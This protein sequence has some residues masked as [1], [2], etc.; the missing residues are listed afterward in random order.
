MVL[1]DVV[2]NHFGPEGNHLHAYAEPFFDAGRHTPWGAGIDY[3]KPPVRRFFIDNALYWLDGLPAGRPAARRDRPDPRPVGPELLAE[4]ARE[5]RA[6]ITDRPVHLTTEDNRNVTHLHERQAGGVS[7]TPPNGTTTC[8]TRPMCWPPARPT[9]TTA[10]SRTTPAATSPARWPRASPSRAPNAGEPSA[11]LPPTAFVDFLQNH[12]QTGN[13]ALGER[14]VTLTDPATHDALTAILLLSP[15]IPLMFMGEDWGETRPFLFFADFA[16]D[17]GRAV[18][19]GRRREFADFPAFAGHT[20]DIPDPVDP[21]TFAASRLDWARRDSPEGREARE[22]VRHLLHL[23]RE[24]IVPHL[25][26]RAAMPG[27]CGKRARAASPSTGASA[28]CAFPCAPTSATR[29][30]PARGGGRPSPPRGRG[31][32]RAALGR[33]LHRGGPMKLPTATYRLQFRGGMDFDRAT[34]LVPYLD[35]LGISHLYAAP[36]FTATPGSAHGYDITDPTEIDPALGGRA[37]LERLS[38]ALTARGMGL[39]LDIVPNHMA[40]APE[41]PWLRDVLRHGAE[42]ASP[43]TSTSTWKPSGCACP[44]SPTISRPC[45]RKARPRSPRTLTAPCWPG[46]AARAA[47]RHAR[48]RRRAPRPLAGRDPP[49]A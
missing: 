39:I 32:R 40:F 42:A 20:G 18:T 38:A 17:L 5:V 26:A 44:G 49:A 35:D 3:T 7:S 13:R 36:L 12:D 1:L 15:H 16:G 41:T 47:G 24:R 14:L 29:R 9:P 46:R 31:P 11:H 4:L 27:R 43:A 30:R 48:T 25:A 45:W 37:G 28:A 2:W 23:R 19:E 8:T 33:P 21:A 10:P 34:A 6:R 22:K